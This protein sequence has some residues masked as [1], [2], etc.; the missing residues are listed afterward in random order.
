M[1]LHGSHGGSCDESRQATPTGEESG[2]ESAALRDQEAELG[3]GLVMIKAS[4]ES[5]RRRLQSNSSSDDDGVAGPL[6]GGVCSAD[7]SVLRFGPSMLERRVRIW[8]DGESRW[9]H[10]FVAKYRRESGIQVRY[11][12]GDKL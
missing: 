3:L 8:W 10:G 2:D 6:A 12:D 4:G 7:V 11:A 5:K 1:Q 9:F